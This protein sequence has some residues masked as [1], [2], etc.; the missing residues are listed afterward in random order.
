MLSQCYVSCSKVRYEGGRDCG[1]QALLDGRTTISMKL[2][3]T[4]SIIAIIIR[5]H[6][7]FGTN[8][9]GQKPRPIPYLLTGLLFFLLLMLLT[10][11]IGPFVLTIVEPLNGGQSA[12]RWSRSQAVQPNRQRP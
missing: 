10:G 3:S 7:V 5:E 4:V 2:L 11:P 9:L 1:L 8:T 12:L 6:E